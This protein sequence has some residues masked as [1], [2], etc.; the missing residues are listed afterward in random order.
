MGQST[1]SHKITCSNDMLAV[2]IEFIEQVIQEPTLV[3]GL[4]YGG[5]LARGIAH[6]KPEMV[7]GMFLVCPMIYPYERRRE[8]H[9]VC[10]VDEE[11]LSTLP[12]DLRDDFTSFAVIQTAEVF[13]RF[14]QDIIP[15]A[16]GGD[17][18]FLE[19]AFRT[20]NFGFSFDPDEYAASY[21]KPVTFIAGKHDK[22]VGYKDAIDVS[23]KY[24]RSTLAVL[25]GTGHLAK[26]ERPEVIISLAHDWLSRC[27]MKQHR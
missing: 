25:D 22:A 13:R 11:F 15:G 24:P 21:V 2:T 3:V 17:R 1:V 16:H 10:E 20:K 9:V 23:T 12:E 8:E 26:I 27:D 6:N 18:D 19:S 4:S 14:K 5:Y 7:K